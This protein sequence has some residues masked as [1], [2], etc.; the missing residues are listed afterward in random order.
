[1]TGQRWVKL[2]AAAAVASLMAADRSVVLAQTSASTAAAEGC[3]TD[4]DASAGVDYFPV[5]AEI[6]YAESFSVQYFPAYKVVTISDLVYVLYQCGTP[7][8]DLS[9]DMVVQLYVSVPV[10]TVAT[11]TPDHI[12]RIEMLGHRDTIVAYTGDTSRV[13]S[14]CVDS[15]V[16]DGSVLEAI[17]FDAAC[18]SNITDNE[19]LISESVEVAFGDSLTTIS[20]FTCPNATNTHNGVAIQLFSETGPTAALA[21]GEGIKLFALFY[22]E[23]AL[24]NSIFDEI[25]DLWSCTKNNAQGCSLRLEDSPTVAWFSYLPVDTSPDAY[26]VAGSF[27]GTSGNDTFYGHAINNTGGTL[28][29]CGE[30]FGQ[31]TDAEMVACYADADVCVF[32][33]NYEAVVAAYGDEALNQLS[34]V[35]NDAAYDITLSGINSWFEATSVEPHVLME[36][37]VVVLHGEDFNF[38]LGSYERL[39]LRHVAS[40]D[41]EFGTYYADVGTC[42][43]PDAVLEVQGE[44]DYIV[45]FESCDELLTAD[46]QDSPASK[47]LPGAAAAAVVLAA[48]TASLW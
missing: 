12:P 4:Y 2:A 24:G 27:W 19:V 7:E 28:I 17:T 13:G 35:Q 11:G 18:A 20:T 43:D 34:C 21:Q 22:N 26:D 39:L 42:D 41:A 45:D 31:L 33:E 37:M 29:W 47:V 44:C 5:K 14:P 3:V 10:T 25:E 16:E 38:G 6:E 23:E 48:L 32:G 40:E 1:M 8:P 36:D 9:A 15:L 30:P 46:G